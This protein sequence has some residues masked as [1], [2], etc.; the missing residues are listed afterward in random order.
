[1]LGLIRDPSFHA[2]KDETTNSKQTTNSKNKGTVEDTFLKFISCHYLG[3]GSPGR[4]V[5]KGPVL[6]MTSD[7]LVVPVEEPHLV[8]APCHRAPYR[9][10]PHGTMLG[11]NSCPLTLLS[12][13]HLST[14]VPGLDMIMSGF[15]CMIT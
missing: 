3:V 1:M 2:L 9:N 14:S 13:S 12:F 6:H 10:D 11:T 5:L 7:L 4:C 8:I 15:I